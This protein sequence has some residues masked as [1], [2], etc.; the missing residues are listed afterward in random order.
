MLNVFKSS[1][2]QT[3]PDS[4]S[5]A[6]AK[7]EKASRGE[8]TREKI[9]DTAI[10]LFREN[11]FDATTMRGVATEA[12]VALGLAY[13]YFPSKEAVVM[14]YYDR[15]QW[16]H[17]RVAH[18]KVMQV[19]SLSERL[20]LL[21]QTKLD[22]LKDDRKLLGALFRYTGDPDHPLSFLGKGTAPL[23]EDCIRLF[24]E[25][26][27]QE[28]LPEDLRE[29]L[30]RAIWA[31]HMG[32]LLY[33]LYDPTTGQK[34]TRKLVTGSIELTVSFLRLAKLPLLHPVRRGVMGLLRE[35]KLIPEK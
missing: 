10:R 35:A 27:E 16:E 8:I 30:P 1:Q 12:G 25:A 31:L 11:G 14:A 2:G 20:N 28:K 3:T 4:P 26:L 19:R 21:F 6:F 18:E 32:V 22:I 13:H 23:R 9:L 29:L 17:R 5:P 24:A 33:L 15:V 34:R 7:A